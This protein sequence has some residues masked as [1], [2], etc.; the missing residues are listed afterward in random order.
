[1]SNKDLLLNEMPSDPV[2]QKAIKKNIQEYVDSM[3][4]ADAEKEQ[5]KAILEVAEEKHGVT[6]AFIK[7]QAE[8]LYDNLYK[9]SRKASKIEEQQNMLETFESFVKG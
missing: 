7:T 6:K 8:L 4:L 1:M 9:D 3:L 5:M 2:T